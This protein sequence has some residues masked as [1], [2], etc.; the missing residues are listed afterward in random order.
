MRESVIY[1]EWREE[2]R[3]E[4]RQE[5]RQ[6]VRQEERL[7]GERSLTLRLLARKVGD[8]PMSMRS[9]IEALSLPQLEDLAEA[10]L[11]FAT[12][13]DLSEWLG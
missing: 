9:Q 1:Q 6:E 10:L 7:A 13:A 2:A 12:L 5:L 4:A 11:D 8:L 3:E